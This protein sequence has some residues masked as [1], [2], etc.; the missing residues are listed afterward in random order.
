MSS[1]ANILVIMGDQHTAAAM[2]C[3]GDPL[4]RWTTTSVASWM[5]WMKPASPTTPWSSQVDR[6]NSP[7]C[8]RILADLSQVLYTNWDPRQV[9]TTVR[10]Q[11]KDW[12]RLQAWG[13]ITKP[14]H[15][16]T[17][18]WPGEETEADLELL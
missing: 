3:A 8:A 17:Y 9:V 2:G 1:P 10:Q 7:D 15:P 5:R 4:I 14:T 12:G 16:D 6:A 13:R 11:L 18:V